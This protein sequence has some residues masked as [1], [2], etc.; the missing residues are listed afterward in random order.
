LSMASEAKPAQPESGPECGHCVHYRITWDRTAPFGCKLFGFKSCK[1][2][3][4]LVFESS[5]RHCG[6]FRCRNR[7]D[8]AESGADD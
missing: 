5:G 3:S 7:Q 6:E 2:P 4:R 8:R 1:K